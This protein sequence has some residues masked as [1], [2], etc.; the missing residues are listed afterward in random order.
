M[1]TAGSR[2]TR[3]VVVEVTDETGKPVQHAAVSF[4]LP[5]DGPG[6]IF[7]NGLRTE[8]ALT[9]AKG[10]AGV[11]SLQW[12]RIP[13]RLQIRI[14]ASFEQ[15]RAGVTSS[16]Y[17]EGP[18]NAAAATAISG[19][20]HSRWLWISAVAAGAAAGGILAARGGGATPTPPAAQPT[21]A[22]LTIGTP[23][24]TVVKP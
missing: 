24:I 15:A 22:V 3:P 7:P 1:H 23:V 13:G 18:A 8:V 20:G 14:V 17:I 4:H 2:N 21:P 9:D 16:Q 12:N 10:R 6:G 5:E 11:H 19:G